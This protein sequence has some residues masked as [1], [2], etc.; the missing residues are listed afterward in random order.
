MQ[1]VVQANEILKEELLS[2]G[3]GG[4]DV[5]IIWI[6]K[7]EE[8]APH[9]NA[10]GYIDLLFDGQPGRIE[11]LKN[12]LPKPVIVNSVVTTLHKMNVSFVRINAWPGFLKRSV[13]EATG[14][15]EKIKLG[16]SKIF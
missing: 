7:V 2:N 3:T 6:K 14:K 4:G 11:Q 8:F 9:K 15:D 13:I 5:E 16:V 10:D 12:F 1:L